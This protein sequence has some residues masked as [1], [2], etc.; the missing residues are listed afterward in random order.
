MLVTYS[1]QIYKSTNNNW[2]SPYK[3]ANKTIKAIFLIPLLLWFLSWYFGSA[4]INL[5]SA[6][7]SNILNRFRAAG[8]DNNCVW[9]F[10][11]ETAARL[12]ERKRLCVVGCDGNGESESKGDRGAARAKS[13]NLHSRGTFVILTSNVPTRACSPPPSPHLLGQNTEKNQWLSVSFSFS[14]CRARSAL[15]LSLSL[16]L[17]APRQLIWASR[18]KLATDCGQWQIFSSRRA[19]IS[20]TLGLLWNDYVTF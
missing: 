7:F 1:C 11:S 3:E 10:L 6:M 15:S 20:R 2:S 17:I 12:E 9:K 4:W 8:E 16:A 5:L 13:A 14:F 19:I 18:P